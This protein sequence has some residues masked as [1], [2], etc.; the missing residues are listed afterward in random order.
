MKKMLLVLV[1][2]ALSLSLVGCKTNDDVDDD[3]VVTLESLEFSGLTDHTLLLGTTFDVFDSVVATGNDG[4]D[5][6]EFITVSSDSCYIDDDGM[7]DT[8][9]TGVCVIDYTVVVEGKLERESINVTLEREPIIIDPNNPTVM[10]WVFDTDA[11]LTGWNIYEAAPG[12]VVASHDVDALKLEVTS[13]GNSWDARYSYQ[14]V[15]LQIG[16][17]YTV[18]FD[19]KTDVDGKGMKLQFGELIAY[20]PWFVN[21]DADNTK[22]IYLT[23]EWVNYSYSFILPVD[24]VNG[25]PLFE[26]GDIPDSVGVDATV[27][28]D[29]IMI[30]GP[31]GADETAPTIN[32]AEDVTIFVGDTFDNLAGID[33]F[34]FVDGD[35]LADLV[36]TGTVD[37]ATVG[38][39]TVNYA[40]TDEAGNATSI[41]R[42]VSVIID[43]VAPVVEGAADVVITLGIA[44]DILDSVTAIDN[45]DGDVTANIV[46]GGDEFDFE[47]A[48]TY[49]ITYTVADALLNEVVVTRTLTVSALLF[50][51][52]D[53]IV[54]G[55]FDNSGWGTYLATWNSTDASYEIVDGVAVWNVV[56][57]GDTGW[58][59]QFRQTGI[60]LTMDQQYIL[61][62]DAMSTVDRDIKAKFIAL[63]GTEY[64]EVISL[65]ST[66]TT[67]T[68]IFTFDIETQEGKIDFELGLVDANTASVVTFDNVMLE[69]YDGTAAVAETD[70]VTNGD[71]ELSDLDGWAH[72]ERSWDPIITATFEVI[73]GVA[74]YT[75]DGIGDATWNVK[76]QQF[77]MNFELGKT[78]KLSFDAKG[79][80]AKEFKALFYD[81]STWTNFVS[82]ILNLTD[83]WQTFE[84]VFTYTRENMPR[85][86]FVLGAMGPVEG[87]VFYLDNVA[88]GVL[89]QDDLLLNGDFET[90]GWKTYERSWDPII[91]ATFELVD[92]V[93]VYTYD[94]VGDADWNTKIQFMDIPLVNGTTYV[95]TY[96]AKGDAAKD[97]E[98]KFYEGVTWTTHSPGVV[99]LTTEWQTFTYTF[100]YTADS[101]PRL[102]FAL[103]NSGAVEGG[104]F[105]LDNVSVQEWDG[106]AVVADTELVINGTFDQAVNWGVWMADWNTTDASVEVASG[107]VV[108]DIT[109]VGTENWNIQLFQE[110]IEL[111]EGVTYTVQFDAM[112]SADRD[113]NLK[114]ITTTEYTEMF[115]LTNE[116][117]TY[118]YSFVYTEAD[119]LGKLD[120]ELGGAMNGIVV[121]V[122]SIVTIDNVIVYPNYN[123][124]EE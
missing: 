92:G 93:A 74:V 55:T 28:L 86:E 25:G 32:G 40:A 22:Y 105:Y 23:T 88:I 73:D 27:W 72:Y 8:A 14:G 11:D 43:D 96:D 58:N 9:N 83:E 81:E 20:D 71:F 85:L 115:S 70:M 104:V 10:E 122:P 77:D 42:V 63:D 54:N 112:S 59:I 50:D 124:V 90:S 111:K 1:A 76:L 3:P 48:G 91:T 53:L 12:S 69:E 60:E 101:I 97:F 114:M 35:M 21:F 37:T 117:T 5:Y 119:G 106:T 39:Y 75:Y 44:F 87:G 84:F 108:V 79:D 107:E 103:G 121:S 65:T 82:P 56:D 116:M 2:V 102:E 49:V 29:N 34:D 7:L 67:Y 94:G 80:A 4:E 113:I 61:S 99:G 6:T 98:A 57:T 46:V 45:R 18:S 66:M 120:F 30:Q 68:V 62:F 16:V 64:F 123:P 100:E 109:D 33:A 36:V 118:T 24:N 47:T 51:E 17:A 78:Y 19:A 95:L 13:G 26:M 52:T 110:G 15:P 89:Q 41:D 38:E 31:G